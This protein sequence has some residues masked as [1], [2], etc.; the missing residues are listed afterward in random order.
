MFQELEG[1][2]VERCGGLMRGETAGWFV[3]VT[4]WV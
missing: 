2:G 4:G 3:E 1:G